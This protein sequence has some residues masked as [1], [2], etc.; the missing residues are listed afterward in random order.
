MHALCWIIHRS[1][2][3]FIADNSLKELVHSKQHSVRESHSAVPYG[4]QK[5]R[6]G[7]F[8]KT[9]PFNALTL[10]VG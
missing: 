9:F 10:L 3:E 1:M 4:M 6:S 8:I 2:L 7:S 5:F